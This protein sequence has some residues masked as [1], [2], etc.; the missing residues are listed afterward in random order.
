MATAIAGGDLPVSTI[1]EPEIPGT[2]EEVSDPEAALALLA[3]SCRQ[4][5]VLARYSVVGSARQYHRAVSTVHD[6]CGAIAHCE[7]AGTPDAAIRDALKSAREIHGR[8]PFVTRLQQWPRGYPGDFETI[9]WLWR[10]DN[11]APS[12]TLAHAIETYALNSAIAQQHRN[13]VSFQGACMLQAFA[14]ARPC[15]MLSIGCGSS[16][17]LRTVVEHIPPSATIVLCDSDQDALSFSRVK[18]DSIADRLHLVHGMVP[19]V[20]RRVREHGPYDLILAGGLF[21]YLSDQ[22]IARTLAE[23]WHQLLAPDGRIVFTNIAKGNPFRVWIEYMADW[24]LIERSEEDIAAICHAA[25]VPATP[26]MVRDA[27]S[28]AIVVTLKKSAS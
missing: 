27:T 4:L 6:I 12:G 18:L 3:T 26:I 7:S 24:K 14:T 11:R 17:D 28:L 1:P 16:P 19:R 2:H 5:E 8:S 21:D 9:E 23:A 25:G 13:K 10:G 20:L 22:F 15:R